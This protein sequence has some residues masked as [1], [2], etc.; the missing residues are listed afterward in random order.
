MNHRLAAWAPFVALVGAGC[1]P[2]AADLVELSIAG[3]A[4][5]DVDTICDDP[6]LGDDVT[7][8]ISFEEHIAVD[9]EATIELRQYKVEYS[10]DA[11]DPAP[12]YFADTL[13]VSVTNGQVASFVV[14]LAAA[15]QREYVDDVMDG[16]LATGTATLTFAGY[17]FRDELIELTVDVP[18]LFGRY[19]D[20][21]AGT[22]TE[23]TL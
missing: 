8:E 21:D 3:G 11:V 1:N 22:G 14:D 5:V 18:I 20:S 2:V 19:D 7:A 17:D 23:V 12:E 13:A 6:C 16:E 10:F 15:S 4:T 9:V